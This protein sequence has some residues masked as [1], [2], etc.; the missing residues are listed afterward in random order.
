MILPNMLWGGLGHYPSDLLPRSETSRKYGDQIEQCVAAAKKYGLEVH[1]WKV[2]FNLSG[3]LREF[4]EQMRRE[5]RTQVDVH[6]EPSN[7]L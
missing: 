6:G 7:W 2:N 3:L 5:G 4:V 1:V